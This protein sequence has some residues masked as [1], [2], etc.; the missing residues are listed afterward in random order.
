MSKTTTLHARIDQDTKDQ[1][2]ALAKH[3]SRSL[4]NMIEVLIKEEYNRI[5]A[6]K[7]G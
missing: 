2:E 7:K 3:Y 6:N 1:L 5:W 4:T